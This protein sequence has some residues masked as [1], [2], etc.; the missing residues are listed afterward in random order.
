MTTSVT[1]I[2]PQVS[3]VFGEARRFSN[4]DRFVLAKL[5]LDS[6]VVDIDEEGEW[7]RSGLAALE[8]DWDNQDDAIYDDWRALYGVPDDR[9]DMR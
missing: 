5:L 4:S 9:I 2:S 8:K 7:Q 6:V 3:R 1:A